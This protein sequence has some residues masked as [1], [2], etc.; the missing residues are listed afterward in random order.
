MVKVIEVKEMD[1]IS[2]SKI[3]PLPTVQLLTSE[4][5]YR[6]AEKLGIPFIFKLKGKN[7]LVCSDGHLLYHYRD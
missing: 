2:I 3:H 1:S 6:I 5:L 7:H 4:D